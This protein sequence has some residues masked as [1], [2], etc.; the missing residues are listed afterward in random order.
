M[1]IAHAHRAPKLPIA[2]YLG[3]RA[4]QSLDRLAPGK[5]WTVSRTWVSCG[6]FLLSPRAVCIVVGVLFSLSMLP[7]P[8]FFRPPDK[9]I[10][11]AA[12]RVRPALSNRRKEPA[13]GYRETTPLLLCG[14]EFHPCLFCFTV[15][16]IEPG[17]FQGQ[18][19]VRSVPRVEADNIKVR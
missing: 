9:N 19:V 8:T 16:L 2:F 13:A 12:Q 7:A 15:R 17:L 11:P 4:R 5:A 18:S 3:A 10:G 14:A 1:G 6:L